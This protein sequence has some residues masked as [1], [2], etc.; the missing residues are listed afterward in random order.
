MLNTLCLIDPSR[1]EHE[2][3]Q[4]ELLTLARKIVEDDDWKVI[5][6]MI[7]KSLAERNAIKEGM[8]T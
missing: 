6:V 2:K 5:M 7:D 4:E 8:Y 3:D 1:I